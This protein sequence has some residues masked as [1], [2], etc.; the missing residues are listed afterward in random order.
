M[1]KNEKSSRQRRFGLFGR[2]LSSYFILILVILLFNV[3][4]YSQAY[5]RVD[6]YLLESQRLVLS[7]AADTLDRLFAEAVNT[8]RQ[9]LASSQVASLMYCRENDLNVYK[10]LGI[11]HLQEELI[12]RIA[13]NGSI[14]SIAVLF[15]HSGVSASNT[16]I[17]RGEN[18]IQ[19]LSVRFGL[20]DDQLKNAYAAHQTLL[21]EQPGGQGRLTALVY[22]SVIR[23]NPDAVCLL[24]INAQAVAGVLENAS[25]EWATVWLLDA[26]GRVISPA[27]G[28]AI[29][30]EILIRLTGEDEFSMPLNGKDCQFL[31]AGLS[32]S[33]WK[34]AAGIDLAYFNQPLHRLQYTYLLTTLVALSLGVLLAVIFTHQ[35]AKRIRRITRRFIEKTGGAKDDLA[36]LEEGMQRLLDENGSYRDNISRHM[37]EIRENWLIRVMHGKIRSAEVFRQGCCDYQT[38]FESDMF[39]VLC[40]DVIGYTDVSEVSGDTGEDVFDLINYCLDSFAVEFLSRHYNSQSC[41]YNN[42]FY[43]LLNLKED[44]PT[45]SSDAAAEK[46]ALQEACE[47]LITYVEGRI[48]VQLRCYFSDPVTGPEG[49][50]QAYTEVRDGIQLMETYNI[51]VRVADRASLMKVQAEEAETKAEGESAHPISR[52]TE[53]VCAYIAQNYQDPMMTV[54]QLSDLFH[55][56]QSYLLRIFKRDLGMGVLEYISQM[57]IQKAKRL[58][59]E[60]KDTVG[61]IAEQVGYTN[62]L[63]LI[64]AFRKQENLTPTEYR[65]LF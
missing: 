23:S 44:K 47:A 20:S 22:D 27:S 6:A 25:D 12:R 36:A 18:G 24:S 39:A 26:S 42:S 53:Q 43:Y 9:I 33:P 54:S 3:V 4:F 55:L 17:L 5:R 59:K 28:P 64:R 1:Q 40:L 57:R 58:L 21:S 46:A 8:G 2:I 30:E 45:S 14:E 48:G 60:T 63:A 34:V 7:Q 16:G 29:T 37:R 65:R 19:E 31:S 11:M 10:K 13:Y 38:G 35:R 61:A 50:A 32:A 15:T 51:A 49:I 62:S 56:S 41:M 52:Q